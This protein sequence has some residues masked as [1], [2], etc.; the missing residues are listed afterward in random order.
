MFFNMSS[1]KYFGNPRKQGITKT[2][3]DVC[4]LKFNK[5]CSPLFLTI[6]AFNAQTARHGC[7]VIKHHHLSGLLLQV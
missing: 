6:S 7:N 4:R 5:A 3:A 1:N 2:R